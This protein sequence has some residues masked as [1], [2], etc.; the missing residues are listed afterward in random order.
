MARISAG[1]AIGAG[2]G[3][4]R[5]RPLTVLA[6]GLGPTL[7]QAL[8]FS[9]LAPFYLNY[10]GRLAN[11]GLGAAQAPGAIMPQMMQMQGLSQLVNLVSLLVAAVVYCAVWRAIL[12]PEKSAFAYMRVGLPEFFVVVLTIA[13]IIVFAIAM[14]ILT[15]PFA[16]V[17]G[18]IAATS[19]GAA[20]GAAIGLGIA[21]FVVVLLVA[22]VVV[23]LRFSFAGPMMVEDGAFHLSE[24]W[25][26]T[27]G[28]LGSLLLITLGL[29]GIG[30]LAELVILTVLLAIGGA[31]LVS[32][33]GL[34]HL[35]TLFTQSP[36]ALV[37]RLAPF[38]VVYA[39]V[40]APV[41]G[42]FVTI[43]AAPWAKAYSDLKH[44]DATEVFA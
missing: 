13:A 19:H 28:K 41:G 11:G 42:C 24:S 27:R 26:M 29:I 43:F 12:H 10:F 38:L 9:L 23:G 34:S 22:L 44:G 6:W 8:S 37:S 17:I 7:L 31:A 16:I 3:L 5:R 32:L 25:A 18:V 1:A 4:I 14:V 36:G 30:I 15:V 33:G 40:S 2:F 39:I 21:L 20:A 35:Q